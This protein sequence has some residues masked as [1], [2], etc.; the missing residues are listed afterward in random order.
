MP[1]ECRLMRRRLLPV[2]ALV[3]TCLGLSV[4]CFTAAPNQV[5][6]ANVAIDVSPDG[7]SVV[8]SSADGDLFLLQLDKQDVRRLTNTA[9]KETSPAFSPD[10]L[11]LVYAADTEGSRGTFIFVRSLDGQRVQQ[12]TSDW[13]VSDSLPQYSPDASQIVFARAHVYRPYS[14]GGWTWDRWDVYLMDADGGNLRRLTQKGHY[15]IDKVLFSRDG[16]T[17]FYSAE[18]AR[19]PSVDSTVTLFE[20][21]AVDP[22]SPKLVTSK[23]KR[24]GKH[25]AWAC[26]PAVSPDGKRF[27]FISDR[28]TPYH[29]DLI[30]MDRQ[31][32][33]SRSL[34]ATKISR[35]NQDPVITPD[36]KG[37]LFLAGTEWNASSRPIFSLWSMDI[38]G[39]NAKQVADSGLFTDPTSWRPNP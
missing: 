8:F 11:S 33:R 12:L 27:V 22:L 4:G 19:G 21:S 5:E 30:L 20:V 2:G 24:P 35:C 32:G 7:R 3:M 15:G 26:D 14:M 17:V 34:A 28:D 23:P 38:D 9:R 31:N 16:Q 36:G 25:Y 39:G 10:G 18:T 1:T 13:D 29:Y 37:I 6:H